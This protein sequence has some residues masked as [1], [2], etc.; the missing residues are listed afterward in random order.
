[1]SPLGMLGFVKRCEAHRQGIVPRLEAGN[2]FL[3]MDATGN[4][5]VKV[6]DSASLHHGALAG[7]G[8]TT[9]RGIMGS[10]LYIPRQLSSARDVDG[11]RTFGRS[12]SSLRARRGPPR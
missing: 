1:M 5:I 9:T 12:A 3:T 7:R 11:R 2:L 4:P 8:F 10:P 6:L